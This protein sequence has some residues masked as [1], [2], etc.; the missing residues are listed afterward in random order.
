M[1]ENVLVL[2]CMLK[3]LEMK[4]HDVCNLLLNGSGEKNVHMKEK[5]NVAK[6]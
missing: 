1:L 4:C 3:A 6:C 5:V 2:R